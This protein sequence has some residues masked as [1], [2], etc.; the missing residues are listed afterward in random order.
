MGSNM[1]ISRNEFR[2]SCRSNFS[3]M[4]LKYQDEI[5]QL[6][7]K[8]LESSKTKNKRQYNHHVVFEEKVQKAVNPE[9][10]T[11]SIEGEQITIEKGS[12]PYFAIKASVLGDSSSFIAT[13]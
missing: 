9:I 11:T 7:K 1:P 13:T 10:K 2:D 5:I 6:I 8:K 12:L 4:M 3:A